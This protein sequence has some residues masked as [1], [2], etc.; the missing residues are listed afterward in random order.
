M[1]ALQIVAGLDEPEALPIEAIRAAQAD[2]NSMVPIF[3][4]NIE[5]ILSPQGAPVA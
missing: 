3:L 1:D 2:R 5:E 4:R